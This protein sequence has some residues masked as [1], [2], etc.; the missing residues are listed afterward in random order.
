MESQFP[1]IYARAE[2]VNIRLHVG[3]ITLYDLW[4]ARRPAVVHCRVLRPHRAA[5]SRTLGSGGDAR[6]FADPR[7]VATRRGSSQSH[8]G[9]AVAGPVRPCSVGPNLVEFSSMDEPRLPCRLE[10]IQ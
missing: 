6:S 10:P 7:R 5:R 9:I 2:N 3:S 8:P 4:R 1:F